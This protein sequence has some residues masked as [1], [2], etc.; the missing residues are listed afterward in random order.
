[1]RKLF[2]FIFSFLLVITAGGQKID[3]SILE[4]VYYRSIGPTRQGGR[5]IDFAVVDKNPTTFYAALATGGLWKTDDNGISFKVLF[6]DS[7]AISIGDIAVDQNNPDI[8]WVGT[9]EANN[10]RTAYYGD[11]IY[12]SEDGGLSWENMGLH[13]SHHIGRII[14][15]PDNPDIVWVAALGHLYSE[16]EERG[17]YKTTNG[18][19]KWDKVLDIIDHGKNIGVVDLAIDPSDPDILYA[20]AYDKVRRPWTFNAG[21]PASRIYKT[22]DGGRKW[23]K[24]TEGL[25]SGMLG[26]IGIAVS[27]SDPEIVYANIEN[28]NIPGVTDEE[29][30]NQLLN[31]I[32][33][34]GKEIGD[35]VYRSDDKGLTWRKVSPDG[36]DVGGGPAYY[37]QQM[38]IDPADPDHVYVLGVRMWETVNGG[39]EWQRPFNFGGD[40]HAMWIDPENSK[41]IM[42]GYDH[43]MGISYDRGK[44]WYHPDYKDVGQFV[45][46]GYDMDYPYNVYGGMQDNGSVRGPSTKRNGS[47]VRLEDWESVGG[48]DGMYNVVDPDNNRWLYNESQFGPINRVD[49]QTGE[50]TSIRFNEMDRWSWNAPIVIS[51]HNSSTI[52]HAGN[53]VAR[54][55]NRGESWT[56]ISTDITTNDEAKIQ[57]TGNIQ[58]CNIVSLDES[59]AKEG[60]IWAG[61]DDGKVWVTKDGGKEWIDLTDNIPGHPGYWVS[62]L[63]PSYADAAAAYLTVTGYRRD[64][65]RPLVWKTGDYGK[66]W[67]SISKG[68]PDEP[69][70][71]IREHPDNPNLLFVGSTK[72]VYVSFDKGNTWNS[73]RNNMPYC[74]VED[75]RIHP[76]ENDL[77]VATHGRSIWIADISFLSEIND[78][79]MRSSLVLFKP[80]T[81]YQW[82]GGLRSHS[83]SSNFSGESES[84]GVDIYYYTDG[85]QKAIK[86]HVLDGERI[87]FEKEA[88]NKTGLHKFHWSH[89]KIIR[90]RTEQEIGR[91]K[92]MLE[93]YKAYGFT[94]KDLIERFGSLDYIM[95]KVGPGKYK[96]Q[97]IAGDTVME[98]EM[99]VMKDHWNIK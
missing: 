80:E 51:P 92:Q 27:P 15:H 16:N 36:E 39:D 19:K 14:I 79:K 29:R 26:R 57:G 3:K 33:P 72:A 82:V 97:L 52:Y 58:Y 96:V 2:L 4:A 42:L 85:S 37:Y 77:I 53:R 87:I 31:G 21:G 67:V 6:E 63:E 68:L 98:Q 89:S 23:E 13:E 24:L 75:L 88:D 60:V 41:H 59:P 86:L 8:V 46:V 91:M 65:F 12:K 40:N 78:E 28:N 45:A 34:E 22:T 50:S 5:Y 93:R 10:S 48:G 62:R 55:D 61:T 76:R 47:P 25:P 32:P 66:T 7:G 18:G 11:G 56:F 71:V 43:G 73:L 90:K 69:L 30:Y 49:L 38:A 44:N 64:D 95:G 70:C 20:A 83:S 81:S 9:G 1:M 35:E 74:P 17:V 94:E 54:S 84:Q 99:V